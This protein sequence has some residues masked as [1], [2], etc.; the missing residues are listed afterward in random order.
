MIDSNQ[1][2]G[3]KGH[4][5]PGMFVREDILQWTRKNPQVIEDVVVNEGGL[6]KILGH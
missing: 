5:I 1:V 4:T 2:T 3:E 6:L